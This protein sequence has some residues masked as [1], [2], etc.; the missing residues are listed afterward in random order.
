M[1]AWGCTTGLRG[2][3]LTCVLAIANQKGGVGKTTTSINL[4]AA[5]AL[6]KKKTLLIDLDPQVQRHA[7]H[8]LTPTKF[9][10][11]MYDVFAEHRTEMAKV[12]RPTKDPNLF[13]APAVWRS[14]GSSS[15]SPASSTRP[16]N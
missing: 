13:V 16:S 6:K 12:I 11:T 8:F 4:A 15:S 7:S 1:W 10:A 2:K 14:R 5:I 9:R 3:G